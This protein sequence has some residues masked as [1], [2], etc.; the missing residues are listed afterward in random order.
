VVLVHAYRRGTW[1][2]RLS[3]KD[4]AG[5]ATV[6]LWTL[7]IKKPKKPKKHKK[8]KN[9]KPAKPKTTSPSTGGSSPSA[10]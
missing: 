10:G 3:A 6:R 7:V 5:N 2:A 8:G 4:H 1:V 9:G